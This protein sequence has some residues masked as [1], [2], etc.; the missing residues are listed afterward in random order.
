MGKPRNIKDEIIRLYS[1]G[2]FYNEIAK[3]LKCSKGT[4][5]Y[6]CAEIRI[7]KGLDKNGQW[8]N[9]DPEKYIKAWQLCRQKIVNHYVKKLLSE[10]YKNLS[11]ERLRKRV[12]YE[13]KEK[14]NRCKL[15][16]WL[17]MKIML[18]LEHKDGDRH[19][20][21]RKNVEGLCP[22]CH[23]QTSTWRGKNKRNK[24][25]LVSDEKLIISLVKHG[26]N[27]RRALI[28]VGLAPKGGNYK[29][30]H[31]ISRA[32]RGGQNKSSSTKSF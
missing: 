14:C 13:Q 22:N 2:K 15:S 8:N 20:N 30:C 16:E 1:S 29:R 4:V 17:G 32:L 6:H 31:K 5:S 12:I 25:D 18:E 28:E 9:A 11:F 10:P 24:R 23:S 27:F 7:E 3:E 26:F 21:K 19:N